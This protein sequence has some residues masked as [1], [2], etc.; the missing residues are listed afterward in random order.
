MKQWYAL[1]VSL[2]SYA[3]IWKLIVPY[4][5]HIQWLCIVTYVVVHEQ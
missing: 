2:Y 3:N 1:Y 5:V 4:E